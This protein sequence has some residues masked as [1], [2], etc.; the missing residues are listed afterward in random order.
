MHFGFALVP[1]LAGYW[2]LKRT[3]LLKHAYEQKTHY[4]V[5]FEPALV[6]GS[7]LIAAWLVARLFGVF[8]E[9]TA[10]LACVGDLWRSIAPFDHAAVLLLTVAFALAI[11]PAV[12]HVVNKKDAANRWAVENETARGKMLRGSLEQ[13]NLVEVTLSNGQSY[14]GFVEGASTTDFEGDI[15]L[16]P[17]LS[18][19]RDAETHKLVITAE[20]ESQDDDYRVVLLLDE[21]ASV[22][23]FDP[24]NRYVEWNLPADTSPSPT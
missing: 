5:F 10:S 21:M 8:F 20:Y 13:G 4:R 18:G 6:G 23:N 19:Y 2:V 15:A 11:P 22:S 7:M 9:P 17:E 24:L 16:A 1:V 3:H 14:I 12:N